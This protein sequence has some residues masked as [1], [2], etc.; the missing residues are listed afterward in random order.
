MFGDLYIFIM[1]RVEAGEL[2]KT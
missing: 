1:R 2:W